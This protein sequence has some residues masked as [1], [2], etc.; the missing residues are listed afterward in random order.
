MNKPTEIKI[1]LKPIASS[2]S[3]LAIR[4]LREEEALRIVGR[5][6]TAYMYSL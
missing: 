2:L 4:H 3:N 1:T 6:V 5:A